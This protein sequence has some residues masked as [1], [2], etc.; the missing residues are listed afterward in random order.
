MNKLVLG[1][2]LGVTAGI[3]V[4]VGTMIFM[5]Q[6][7]STKQAEAYEQ[8]KA[9]GRLA[10]QQEVQGFTVHLNEG[11]AND[12]NRM[13]AQIR[14]AREALGQIKEDDP[15]TLLGAIVNARQALSDE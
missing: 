6:Q 14:A 9:D 8:G 7:L 10:A 12:N 2:M 5:G 3:A 4:A 1:L 11:M 15:D 13:A